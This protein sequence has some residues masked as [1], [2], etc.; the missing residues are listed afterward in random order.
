MTGEKAATMSDQQHD[1]TG[2]PT[3]GDAARSPSE[4]A[5]EDPPESAR[6]TAGEPE[7][8]RNLGRGLAALFGEE[9]EDYASL[10]RVRATKGVPV[11]H[12]HPN[13]LQPRQVF[14]AESLKALSDSVAENGI[15]QP[16]LVRRD[17]DRPGEYQIVAGER[18]WRAAQ[19]ARLHE[20]PVV[21]RELSDGQALEVALV[22]NVQRQ[23]L[24]PIEEAEGYQRLI[25]E[26]DHTQDVLARVVGKSRSHIANT[27]RLLGLPP[28]VKALVA[29]RR[30]SAGHA[31][32]LVGLDDAEA[33]AR[34]IV[35][36]G[37]N[38]RQAERLAQRARTG[39]IPSG[40]G[41][42]PAAAP[43]AGRDKDPDTLALERDLTNLLGLK[44]TIDLHEH[45]GAL[46]VQYQTLE[47]LD[48]ILRRLS[49]TPEPPSE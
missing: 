45:G 40:R 39:G 26:F 32:A 49:H 37:L 21:I 30:L 3:A 23:D 4:R 43:L 8:R 5:G 1:K 46:T 18:R 28:A 19:M 29:E 16:I 20:V 14:E 24:S 35:K 36:D 9:E 42:K 6:G 25:E 41:R 12:L 15:L 13:P 17:P 2:N 10:D 38:V 47:Q 31:R 11:E 22:E 48:D 27:L 33:L 34:R 44:V 7:K